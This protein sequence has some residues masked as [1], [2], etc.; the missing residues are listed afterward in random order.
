MSRAK[1]NGIGDPPAGP[2]LRCQ[3]PDVTTEMQIGVLNSAKILR[4]F[5]WSCA[6]PPIRLAQGAPDHHGPGTRGWGLEATALG[7]LL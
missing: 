4:F 5:P 3:T 2:I 7:L 1:P 6:M